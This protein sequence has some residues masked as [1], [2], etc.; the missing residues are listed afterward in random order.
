MLFTT[1]LCLAHMYRTTDLFYGYFEN[2]KFGLQEM[3]LKG[4]LTKGPSINI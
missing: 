3:S 2:Y 4:F 1:D